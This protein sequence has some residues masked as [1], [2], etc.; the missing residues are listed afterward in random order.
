MSNPLYQALNKNNN[1]YAQ[2]IAE[3]KRMKQTL[4]VNPRDEVQR[5]L[6]SGQITQEQLNGALNFAQQIINTNPNS[7][8]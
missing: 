3:A 5:M 1:P 2:I 4:N 6:N 7:F 8:I